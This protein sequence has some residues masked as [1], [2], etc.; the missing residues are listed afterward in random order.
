MS[1]EREERAVAGGAQDAFV[2]REE[3]LHVGTEEHLVGAV[4]ARK[5]VETERV[6]RVEPRAIEYGELERVPGEEG[7]SGEVETLADGSIS[8]PLFEE[9]LVV[10]KEL[11][12]RER[13]VIRKRTVTEEHVVEAELRKERI[14]VEPDAAVADRVDAD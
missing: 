3:E 14:E 2:R 1:G 13:I 7:D 9:R 12:V 5:H 11:V 4:R 10:R 8:I 6:E